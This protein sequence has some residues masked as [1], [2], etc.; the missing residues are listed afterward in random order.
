MSD[1]VLTSIASQ[2]KDAKAARVEAKTLIDAMKEA[3]EDVTAQENQLR[4]LTM[5]IN[6]WDKML[7]ARGYNTEE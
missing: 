6:K 2:M 5:R 3:G 1:A 4:E 7:Q